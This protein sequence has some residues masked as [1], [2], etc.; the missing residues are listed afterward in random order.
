[1]L[2]QSIAHKVAEIEYQTFR[3][4]QNLKYFQSFDFP[5]M[6]SFK[7]LTIHKNYNQE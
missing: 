2:L 6:F 7:T 4:F 1:M 3:Q 5:L